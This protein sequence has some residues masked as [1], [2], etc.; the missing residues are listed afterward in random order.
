MLECLLDQTFQNFELLIADDGSGD[1]TRTLIESFSKRAP[2]PVH[3]FWHEDQG[4]RKARIHNEAV[5][6]A[7]APLLV[8]IDGD[9]VPERTFLEDH[10]NTFVEAQGQPYVLMGRRVE[11]GAKI[12]ETLTPKNIRRRLRPLSLSHLRSQLSGDS[13]TW[14]RS[15]RVQNPAL[16]SL[17]KLNSVKDLLGANFSLP[18]ALFEQVNGYNEA[19][20]GYW[21]EDGDLFIRLR[22]TGAN[23]IGK[24]SFT[25]CYH[26]YHPQ[27]AYDPER[28]RSYQARLQ[29]THYLRCDLGLTA[30]RKM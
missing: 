22:N 30:D 8:F 7:Q 3:H 28:E 29:D 25:V 19:I 9:I 27:K 18:K 10:F 20:E 1:E 14:F 16:R 23:M 24:K 6:H 4:F 17:L 26:L 13:R 12:T 11:L 15:V 5:R 21:G 2:F